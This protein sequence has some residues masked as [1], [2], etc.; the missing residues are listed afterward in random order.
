MYKSESFKDN[1]TLRVVDLHVIEKKSNKV[2]SPSMSFSVHRGEVLGIAGPSGIGK[3]LSLKAIVGLLH[4]TLMPKGSIYIEDMELIGLNQRD[5]CAL[6][7]QQLGMIFQNPISC[8]DPTQKIKTQIGHLFLE[9]DG[10]KKRRKS[11]SLMREES[12]SMLI[13]MKIQNPEDVLDAYP[14]QLS[15]GMLQRIMIA[16]TAY[17]KPKVLLADEPTTALDAENQLLVLQQFL[18]IKEKRESAI[19]VVSHDLGFLE[20]ISDRVL[21]L[22]DDEAQKSRGYLA[23][24]EKLLETFKLKV[25]DAYVNR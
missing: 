6:R 16:L 10:G 19:L 2:L 12:L 20:K 14:H 21:L 15:G 23:S 4:H 8:F 22:G 1:P 11:K 24:R 18:A 13:S 5:L 25:G 17:Q 7:G 9:N 3:S